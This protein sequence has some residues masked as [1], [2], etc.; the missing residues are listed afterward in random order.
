MREEKKVTHTG[1]VCDPGLALWKF[2][3][4]SFVLN[5]DTRDSSGCGLVEED[6]KNAPGC[7]T[8]SGTKGGTVSTFIQR[9]GG[10]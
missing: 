5:N 2:P 6:A 1:A 9:A 8:L 10:D 7:P 4:T 3:E